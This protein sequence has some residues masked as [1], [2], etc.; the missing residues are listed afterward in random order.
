MKRLRV[1]MKIKGMSRLTQFWQEIGDKYSYENIKD[2][3]KQRYIPFI[4]SGMSVPFGYREWG[5]FLS[6]VV[7]EYYEPNDTEHI[8]FDRLLAAGEYLGLA[9]KIN[10]LLNNGIAEEV[11]KGFHR[12]KMIA[13]PAEHNYLHLLCDA[14]IK[15]FVTTNFDCVIEENAKVPVENVYLPSNL[16]TPGDTA[17]AI[18]SGKGGLIKLHGTWDK[19]ESIIL[20]KTEF[21]YAYSKENTAITRTVDYLWNSSVLLFLGCGLKKDYLIERMLQLSGTG[22]RNWHYAV[23][24]YPKADIKKVKRDLAQLKIR[25]IWFENGKFDQIQVI[26]KM[27]V[28]ADDPEP[29]DSEEE[30]ADSFPPTRKSHGPETELK[31]E[32]GTSAPESEKYLDRL[33]AQV[34]DDRELQNALVAAIFSQSGSS[35]KNHIRKGNLLDDLWNKIFLSKSNYPLSI[36]GEPGTGKSTLLSLLFINCRKWEPSMQAFLIDTHYYDHYVRSDAVEDLRRYL[37]QVNDYICETRK[38]ILFIDGINRFSRGDRILENIIVEWIEKWK[39]KPNIKFVLSIGVLDESLFPPFKHTSGKQP[40]GRKSENRIYLHPVPNAGPMQSQLVARTAY[41]FA[42]ANG[43]K[44]INMQSHK[45]KLS[46]YCK[47]AGGTATDFR[48]VNFILKLLHAAPSLDEFFKTDIGVAFNRYFHT[49]NSE[50]EMLATA[51]YTARSLL[52]KKYLKQPAKFYYLFKSEAIR[53]FFF[54]YYYI[55]LIKNSDV[56]NLKLFDCIFTPGINRFAVDLMLNEPDNGRIIIHNIHKLMENKAVTTSQKNQMAF[57]LG[58]VTNIACREISIE[59]LSKEYKEW[60]W[61]KRMTNSMAMYIRTVGISLI[62]LGSTIYAS[63]FYEKLIYNGFLSRINRNFHIQYFITKGYRFDSTL[64]LDD[65]EMCSAE[66]IDGLYQY[67]YHS[68]LDKNSRRES[69]C[70]NIITILNLTVYKIFYLG[71]NSDTDIQKAQK[72]IKILLSEKVNLSNSVVL[73]YVHNISEFINNG[74]IYISTLSS[75]YHLKEEPRVGWIKRGVN[76]RVPVESVADHTW[77]CCQLALLFLPENLEDCRFAETSEL[78]VMGNEY[79]LSRILQMLIIHDLGEAFT[80]DILT[81]MKS[82]DD[83]KRE[84]S[85]FRSLVTLDTLP[86]FNT[87][88]YIDDLAKEFKERTTYNAK[89]AKDID[90]IEPLIQLFIYRKNLDSYK[91]D[92]GR[93]EW[94]EW[95]KSVETR[96]NTAFG[97]NFLRFLMNQILCYF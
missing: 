25:P 37:A 57:L 44:Q 15:T 78:A 84:S 87:F 42:Q 16:I 10:I 21:D 82:K 76:K 70:I 18:R 55:S 40:L 94:D 96:L 1:E 2:L 73:E 71:K 20:T 75:I 3:R 19:P 41:Y 85:V 33:A 6:S 50:D 89:L 17:E 13:V 62:Y 26:L 38:T 67:L 63:D 35:S 68:I 72:L 9:E 65:M 93:R 81:G 59:I 74:N 95:V 56:Q 45:D 24:A 22:K 5:S 61:S 58:R 60:D 43:F 80:G 36:E 49:I 30:G 8:E 39:A 34:R 11:R 90:L 51:K 83:E 14:G 77:A 88:G 4:G 86:H 52:Q 7:D 53:N 97:K 64:K 91:Q 23:L 27:L 31:A 69:M 54:A 79:N 12:S 92:G 29:D 48:T 47:K 32:D 28:G 46:L 66:N